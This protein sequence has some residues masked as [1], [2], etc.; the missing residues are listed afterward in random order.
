MFSLIRGVIIIGLIFYFSPERD[1]GEPE[2]Q[3]RGGERAPTSTASPPISEDGKSQ[4]GLW[5]RIIGSLTEEVVRTAVNDKAQEAG[6]RL[7]EASLS[8]SQPAPKSASMETA[9]SDRDTAGRAS[10]GQSIR[11]I[12]RCDGAE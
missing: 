4:D 2:Q 7:K 5:N 11:C 9:R 10:P 12:Y 1:L 3:A 8:L 6:L